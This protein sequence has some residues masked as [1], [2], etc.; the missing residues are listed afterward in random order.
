MLLDVF[1]NSPALQNIGDAVRE[2]VPK[3]GLVLFVIV[4]TLLIVASFGVELFTDAF[5]SAAEKAGGTY[6]TVLQ[7]FWFLLYNLPDK[8]NLRKTLGAQAPG[9]V[10]YTWRI[11]FDLSIFLWVGVILFTSITALLVD[12]LNK[13][14]ADNQRRED[15]IADKCFVCG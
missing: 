13:H 7:A 1:S 12:A 4:S 6:G 2:R 9:D 14:R 11:L 10:N 8:G 15:A 3:V 5:D